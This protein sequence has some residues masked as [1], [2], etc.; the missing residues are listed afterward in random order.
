MVMVTI[1]SAV[2]TVVSAVAACF[3][4]R[5]AS[6]SNKIS[7]R[8]QI[9][10]LRG[11]YDGD[12]S[13]ILIKN[14]GNSP[15]VNVRLQ[16]TTIHYTDIGRLYG[17]NIDADSVTSIMPGEEQE[18][19][20]SFKAV[21]RNQKTKSDSRLSDDF[22]TSA[23]VFGVAKDKFAGIIFCDV[24]DTPYLAQLRGRKTKAG[25]ILDFYDTKQY[26]TIKWIWDEIETNFFRSTLACKWRELLARRER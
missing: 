12:K 11:R 9:P 24:Q 18:L 10:I 5:A 7:K 23:Y 15:A 2:A 4:W 3:S 13:V 21:G 8:S 22:L 14:Y 26:T 6:A 25:Y 16:R 17:V 20:V 19:A 1:I